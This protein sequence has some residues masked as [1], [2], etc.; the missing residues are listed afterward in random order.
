MRE[1]LIIALVVALLLITVLSLYRYFTERADTG[2]TELPPINNAFMI[3]LALVISV[4]VALSFVVLYGKP[5]SLDNNIGQ[6]GD[7]IGGLINPSLS[8][9]AL[10]VLLRTMHIQTTEARKTT[11]FLESQHKMLEIERFEGTFF[12]IL[13]QLERYCEVHLRVDEGKEGSYAGNRVEEMVEKRPEFDKLHPLSQYRLAKKHVKDIFGSDTCAIFY[14][15]AMRVINQVVNSSLE[16]ELKRAYLGIVRDA[17]LPDERIILA[18]MAFFKVG[19]SRGVIR[20]W[21]LDYVKREWFASQIV[22]A[23]YKDSPK[24]AWH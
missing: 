8:F 20:L 16:V 11:A 5:L 4:V 3:W 10:L 23:Y 18:N 21:D 6:V 9:L 7:F 24:R 15:R 22:S 17:M 14:L 1:Y 19:R 12:K 13:D 2:V